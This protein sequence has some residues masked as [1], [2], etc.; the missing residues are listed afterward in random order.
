L[1]E[2]PQTLVCLLCGHERTDGHSD[3]SPFSV[4]SDVVNTTVG[5]AVREASAVVA[6]IARFHYQG[7][8]HAGIMTVL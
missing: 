2:T 5:V 7:P 4:G 6:R 3:R 1:S 8:R